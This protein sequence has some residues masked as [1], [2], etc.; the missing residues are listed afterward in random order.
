MPDGALARRALALLDLTNLAE[1]ISPADM[2]ALLSAVDGPGGPVAALCIPLRFVAQ[3]RAALDIRNMHGGAPVRVATVAN[4]PGG[5]SDRETVVAEAIQAVQDGADEIDLVMPWR[6]FLAGDETRAGD[7]IAAVRDV[8]PPTM[9]LKVILETGELGTVEAIT[10]ASRLA[11]ACGADF[12]KT[13]TGR[14]KISATPMAAE[15][16]LTAIAESSHPV[17][18]KISGGLESP[19]DAMIYLALADLV[20]GPAFAAPRTFRL[21]ASRLHEPLRRLVAADIALAGRT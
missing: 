3:V 9:R 20:M 14:T 1:K 16:M 13:S 17:G 21:G 19:E 5:D 15:A 7:L 4:F 10:N 18:L 2:T 8:L 6:A 12:L 11:I